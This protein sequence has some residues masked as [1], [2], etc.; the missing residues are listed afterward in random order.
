ME[1]MVVAQTRWNLQI[2]W[3]KAN[4]H[5]T[6]QIHDWCTAHLLIERSVK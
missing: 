3:C 6:I 4:V 5:T 1:F 2:G